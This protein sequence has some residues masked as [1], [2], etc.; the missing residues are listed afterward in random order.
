MQN[1]PIAKNGV[2]PVTTLFFWKFNLSIRTSFKYLIN[3]PITQILIYSYFSWEIEINEKVI[4]PGHIETPSPAIFL[5]NYW[6]PLNSN[7]FIMIVSLRASSATRLLGFGI[8]SSV[9]ETW[10]LISLVTHINWSRFHE[11]VL[12]PKTCS[13][14]MLN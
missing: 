1:W 11:N 4:Y 8:V 3:T 5:G 7:I 13:K 6:F 12:L 14:F 10:Y 9:M 2:L